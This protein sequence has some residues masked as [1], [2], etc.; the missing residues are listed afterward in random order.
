MSKVNTTHLTYVAVPTGRVAVLE[1]DNQPVNSLSGKSIAAI[2]RGAREI[3]AQKD[4]VAVVIRGAGRAFC[5][6]AEISEFA[7]PD[8]NAPKED[9]LVQAIARLENANVPVVALVHGFALGGGFEVALSCHYRVATADAMFGLPEVNLGLLPGAGGTQR[10]PRI[11]GALPA[12]DMIL[13]GKPINAKKALQL[14]VVDALLQTKDVLQEAIQFIVGKPVRSTAALPVKLNGLSKEETLAKIDE[15]LR[16]PSITKA[17]RGEI[18]PDFI[19]GC[20][21]AALENDF[22]FGMK[23]ENRLFLGL[24]SSKEGRALQHMFF[25]E[26][27]CSKLG[28][29]I[30]SKLVKGAKPVQINK[31]G[32]IGSGTMGGGIAMCCAEAG[33]EVFLVDISQEFLSNGIK[34]IAKNYAR[35]VERKSLTQKQMDERMAKIKP[36]TEYADLKDVDIVVEAVFESMKLKQEIFRKLDQVCK[37]SCIL[38]S[39]TSGL[40][41]DQIA[42]VTKRPELVV[43][44][45]FF[46]PANQMQLLENV[47]GKLSSAETLVAVTEFGKRIRKVPILVGNCPGF[48]GNRMLDPYSFQAYAMAIEGAGVKQVDDA[49]KN[50]IG[51]NMGPF[52]VHDLVGLDVFWRKRKEEG[53]VDVNANISDALCEQGRFGQKTGKGFYTYG[54]NGQEE[55]PITL[56]AIENISHKQGVYRRKN[57]SEIEIVERLLYPL[58][59]EGFKCLEE[60]IASKPSDIDAC[61]VFGYGF[62]RSKGGP[63]KLAEELGFDTVLAGLRKYQRLGH[64]QEYWVPSKLLVRL[65]DEK[66]TSFAKM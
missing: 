20:I 16:Q 41:I 53:T 21:R 19:A 56:K 66:K 43:G 44:C 39:N 32:I 58:I 5:A 59:N 46:S 6:G 18:A 12:C 30:T 27:A 29:D 7:D 14:G 11:I 31:V 25:A 23:E 57:F 60:G 49:A 54:K 62:P 9:S 1:M 28:K 15:M 17:R 42:A 38:A 50:V 34:V 2:G 3:A 10:L 8:P 48:V 55:D 4:V 13:S 51:M 63:M 40:D 26:R 45:H 47:R 33:M 52:S 61:Y 65:V 64:K 36:T 22:A 35:S 37:P 24:L